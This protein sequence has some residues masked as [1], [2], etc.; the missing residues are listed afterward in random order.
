MKYET[1]TA[2]ECALDFVQNVWPNLFKGKRGSRNKEY[3]KVRAFVKE[4]INP[5]EKK[6]P[7]EGRIID[8]LREYGEGRYKIGITL[9]IKK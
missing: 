5:D 2:Q 9:K 6:R 3:M 1:A 8:Y 4:V 7:R